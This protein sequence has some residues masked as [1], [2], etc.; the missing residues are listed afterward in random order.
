MKYIEDSRYPTAYPLCLFSIS[1]VNVSI[2]LSFSPSN[3]P[4]NLFKQTAC[5]WN[6][7]ET[8]LTSSPASEESS[9][10]HM[11]G[12]QWRN[13][14]PS[15]RDTPT[16]HLRTTHHR[17]SPLS[18]CRFLTCLFSDI[19]LL[20]WSESIKSSAKKKL[21]IILMK[22]VKIGKSYIALHI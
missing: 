11:K 2:F 10:Q 6:W 18:V 19:S 1:H 5:V 20:S 21:N 15:H 8:H 7:V 3:S 17:P 16:S 22:N 14:Q 13:H 12:T 4:K 9:A